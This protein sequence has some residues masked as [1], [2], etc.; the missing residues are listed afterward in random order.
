MRRLLVIVSVLAICEAFLTGCKTTSTSPSLTNSNISMAEMKPSTKIADS[1]VP[2]SITSVRASSQLAD[3]T[4][5]AGSYK[6]ENMFDGKLET[7]WVEGVEGSGIGQWVQF[8]FNVAA[9]IKA[10]RIYAGYGKSEQTYMKNGRVKALKIAFSDGESQEAQLQ[11]IQAFQTIRINRESPS[12]SVRLEISA[13]H[14]GST[15]E[16]T[17]ISEVSFEIEGSMAP[18]SGSSQAG[19]TTNAPS[20]SSDKPNTAPPTADG[21]N[22]GNDSAPTLEGEA[23]VQIKTMWEKVYT[24]CGDSYYNYA[25]NCLQYK[26]VTFIAKPHELKDVDKLN[27]TEWAGQVHVTIRFQREYLGRHWS[28]F[29]EGGGMNLNAHKQRGAWKLD[30]DFLFFHRSDRKP[31][32]SEI[33]SS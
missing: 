21:E 17:C 14:E 1:S 7:A 6:P 19:I 18:P 30:T 26:E 25:P 5:P 22:A 2:I 3:E 29:R 15:Y 16:D 32:C 10:I 8:D 13:V 23:E 24:K 31:A 12:G 9:K 11:D 4:S 27:G 33:P 20:A 28:D